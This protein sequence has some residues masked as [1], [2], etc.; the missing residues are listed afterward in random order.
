VPITPIFSHTFSHTV[1]FARAGCTHQLAP[2][3]A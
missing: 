2:Q 3:I 1:G